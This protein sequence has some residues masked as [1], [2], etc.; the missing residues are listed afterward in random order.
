MNTCME[1]EIVKEKLQ[2]T[3]IIYNMCISCENRNYNSGRKWMIN[4][5]RPILVQILQLHKDVARSTNAPHGG[6][7]SQ[8][9]SHVMGR[10]G[11]DYGSVSLLRWQ[12]GPPGHWG[13]LP[14]SKTI[15]AHWVDSRI[16]RVTPSSHEFHLFLKGM[17]ENTLQGWKQASH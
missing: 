2:K 13:H 14:I 16:F 10:R 4:S 17:W 15:F 8:Q 5:S 1:A 9:T 11:G 6:G 7:S 3:S 12:E